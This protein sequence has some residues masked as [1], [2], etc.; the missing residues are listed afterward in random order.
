MHARLVAMRN[1]HST[2][3]VSQVLHV[4]IIAHFIVDQVGLMLQQVVLCHVQGN[5]FSLI[6]FSLASV[7]FQL[8]FHPVIIVGLP[9][10]APLEINVSRLLHVTNLIHSFVG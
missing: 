2:N 10:I 3:F 5:F 9:L 1:V 4:T 8:I 7:L 6:F